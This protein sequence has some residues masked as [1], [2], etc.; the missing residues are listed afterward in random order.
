MHDRLLVKN[1]QKQLCYYN[2]KICTSFYVQSEPK[3]T[4]SCS[5][6]PRSIS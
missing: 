2:L 6:L 4:E 1:K 3:N 5:T